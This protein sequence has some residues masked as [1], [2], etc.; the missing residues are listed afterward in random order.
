M[1]IAK[2]KPPTW[3]PSTFDGSTLEPLRRGSTVT[4]ADP[5]LKGTMEKLKKELA[6]D[7]TKARAFL[8]DVGIITPAGKLSRRFGG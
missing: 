7:P 5:R 2:R 4:L 6:S 3:A 8:L 1:A